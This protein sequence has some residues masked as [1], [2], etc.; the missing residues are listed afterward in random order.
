MKVYKTLA[1]LDF[2]KLLF[3]ASVQTQT[4]KELINKY[5]GYVMTSAVTC[6]LVNNFIKEAKICLYDGGVN[7]V[8]EALCDTINK[9]KYSWALASTC[10]SIS[11]DQNSRNYLARRAVEQVMPLLEMNEQD[12]V[13]YIKSGAMKN[14]MH[15]DAF[16][17]IAKSVYKD[18]PIVETYK[19]FT[20]VHPIS[21][22]EENDGA[23]YF[24]VLGSIYKIDN[25]TREVSEANI[26]EV[27]KE[28][29]AISQLLESKYC[30]F[31]IDSDILSV[32]V[33]NQKFEIT[34]QGKAI[35]T[36]GD[37]KLELTVEQLRE[38]N[39]ITIAT[40]PL[41]V[42]REAEFVLETMVK[43]VENYNSLSIMDNVNII[44][45]NTDKFLLI[46]GQ[47]NAFA[48]SLYSSRTTPWKVS[49]NIVE[50]VK[51][52]KHNTKVDLT[53]VFKDKM[54]SIVEKLSEK[55]G[56]QIKESLRLKELD[57]RRQKVAELTERYKDDPV[58]L[59]LLSQIASDL[60][61]CE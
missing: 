35:R 46:E 8:Y 6:N 15:V 18:Q 50:T 1:E 16:R 11:N 3:E 23:K 29:I 42:R 41:S 47:E 43:L 37:K 44:S 55:E 40:L 56:E 14:V 12:V 4:G 49:D 32:I 51:I 34:E 27:S 13:A 39:Q 58:R 36:I 26:D 17:N 25:E 24:E 53:E 33:R 54:E 30:S 59:Q 22:I 9:N 10:E 20:S 21:I 31:D 61:E 7:Y 28:F 48:K 5:Q 60:N 57:K 45:T 38:Q 52:I 19:Q 2:G